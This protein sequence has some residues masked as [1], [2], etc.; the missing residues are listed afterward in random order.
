MNTTC[1]GTTSSITPTQGLST[2]VSE[3]HHRYEIAGSGEG[4]EG[5]GG[6][7]CTIV[8]SACRTAT[9]SIT[10]NSAEEGE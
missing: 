5:V 1:R 3:I 2:S 4:E 7:H 10:P 9:S 6:V 8:T